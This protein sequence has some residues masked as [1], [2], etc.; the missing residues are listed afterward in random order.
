MDQLSE[1][2]LEERALIGD[3]GKDSHRSPFKARQQV[4]PPRADLIGS[5]IHSLIK[6]YVL[7]V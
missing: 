3:R 1:A 5:F 2:G 7:C 4:L 6:F